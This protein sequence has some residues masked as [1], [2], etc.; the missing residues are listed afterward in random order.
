VAQ[1]MRFAKGMAYRR[2]R[3]QWSL[4]REMFCDW[5][6]QAQLTHFHFHYRLFRERLVLT[7][8]G[9]NLLTS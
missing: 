4:E 8:E 3:P 1:G 5:A 7:L 6:G 9:V 2:S